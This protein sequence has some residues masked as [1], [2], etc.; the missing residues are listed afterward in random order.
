MDSAAARVNTARAARGPGRLLLPTA[1]AYL[2]I[3][4]AGAALSLAY[5]VGAESGTGPAADLPFRG[6]GLAPPLFLPVVLVAAAALARVRGWPGALGAVVVG[7]AGIGFFLG[8]TLNLPN[9]V[10]AARA[11][12]SP[13]GLTI[14]AGVLAAVFGLAFAALAGAELSARVG[15]RARGTT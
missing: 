13:I 6:T 9:D 5:D 11:A 8:G 4:I 2:L 14:A 7:L 12:G 10:D 15:G 1:A 3:A